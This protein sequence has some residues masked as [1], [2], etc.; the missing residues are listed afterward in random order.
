[1]LSNVGNIINLRTCLDFS[2]ECTV[3]NIQQISEFSFLPP[4]LRYK[5]NLNE[6][7]RLFSMFFAIVSTDTVPTAYAKSLSDVLEQQ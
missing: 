2:F 3:L 5:D 4:C 6:F 7:R 1:M